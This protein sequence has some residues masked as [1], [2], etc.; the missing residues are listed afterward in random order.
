M[1]LTFILPGECGKFIARV[2]LIMLRDGY[3]PLIKC[4]APRDKI[5][6]HCCDRMDTFN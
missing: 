2:K 3:W 4:F 5:S 1:T 6:Y